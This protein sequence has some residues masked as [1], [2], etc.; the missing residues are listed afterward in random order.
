MTRF[1]ATFDLTKLGHLIFWVVEK[2]VCGHFCGQK[3]TFCPLLRDGFGHGICE[4]TG[5]NGVKT[6]I[7]G[8][9]RGILSGF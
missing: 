8:H 4:K 3:P 5:K 7:L 2:C 1:V 6:A 9:F